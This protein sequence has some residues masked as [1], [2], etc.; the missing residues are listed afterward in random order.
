MKIG[1]FMTRVKVVRFVDGKRVKYS[2][3]RWQLL[4]NLRERA[5][6]VLEALEAQGLKPIVHGSVARGDVHD[7][8]DIDIVIPYQLPSYVVETA[9]ETYGF[10]PFKKM[11]SQATPSH[12][13]KA[14]IY[15]DE[16]TTITFPLT[17]LSQLEREF[18]KFSGELRLSEIFENKR[19]PGVDKRL[20][21]IIPTEEGHIERSIIG[22]ERE[23]AN[24]L[25]ISLGIVE[26]RKSI[27]LKRDEVGRTGVFL[28]RLVGR[29]QC[30]EEVLK[31]L[32]K[33]NSILRKKL[34]EC[35][36]L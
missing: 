7:G 15:M 2:R 31:E 12:A 22:I 36:F 35:G 18:Y 9:L 16:T 5:V 8:S 14:H 11:I 17:P 33:T 20:M 27:L 1:W 10:V 26:E 34:I 25:G 28:R 23:V 29:G 19:V 3:K 24:L 21:L 30:F 13:I 4:K 32:A 6:K